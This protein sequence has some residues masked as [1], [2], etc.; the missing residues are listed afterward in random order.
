MEWGWFTTLQEGMSFTKNEALQ[1][2]VNL[3]DRERLPFALE[4]KSGQ[5]YT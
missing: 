2:M 4:R 3:Q 5:G 1:T